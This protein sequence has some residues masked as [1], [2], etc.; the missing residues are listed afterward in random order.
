MSRGLASVWAR[1]S[2]RL[3]PFAEVATAGLPL[4]RLLRLALF[5]VSVGMAMVLLIGTLNRVLIVELGIPAW[6]VSLM[7]A[8]PLVFAPFRT[9]VGFRSDTHRSAL[10]WRRVPYLWFG[11]LLQF[12]GLAIMPFAL[13]LLSGDSHAKPWVGE[14]AAA[15][16]FLLTGAGLQTTQTAGL[17]LA[18][19]LAPEADR[20]RV[21][22]LMYGMLLLGMLVSGLTL[23]RLLVR[24]DEMRLIQVIQSVAVVT[25]LLNGVALWKQEARGSAAAI[26][27]AATN[28]TDGW[29]AYISTAGARRFL[30][31]VALGTAAFNMQ[32]IVLEP[33][34]GQV[35]GLSVGETT[36]LTAILAA[37]MLAAFAVAAATLRAG[38]GCRLAA[39]GALCGVA[40][41]AAIIF[42]APLGSALLFRLGTAC[43]GFGA[44]L[45]AA[46]TL[47]RAMEAPHPQ[48]AGLALG[49][50]GAM[51]AAAAG[52]AIALGGALRDLV[53]SAASHGL[54]GPAL[55]DP[56]TGYCVVYHLEI[57]LLFAT[58]AAVGP[59]VRLRSRF[60]RG[61]EPGPIPPLLASDPPPLES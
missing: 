49:A 7:V 24:F 21:V 2:T 57:G 8:L 3:L 32:D 42:A 59:L 58:L 9:L 36:S 56:S 17:A 1:V 5:Q 12:G 18:T 10:G 4:P 37:G 23:G 29:R 54:L 26:A 39:T 19:D 30:W 33:Y 15:L 25:L 22:A 35:L 13:I 44:G 20:P 11:T 14:F 43:N 34:G 55:A 53:G 50:W 6:L 16:A 51:Q 41:F 60:D 61:R 31:V 38:E 47:A 45:F 27:S 28:F 52:I 40:G 48:A 46:G